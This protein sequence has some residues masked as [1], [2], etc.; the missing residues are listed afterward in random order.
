M[1]ALFSCSTRKNKFFNRKYHSI[2]AH[3]NAYFNG[4]EGLKEGI[5]TLSKS[6][7]D[8]YTTILPVYRLGTIENAQAVFPQ[9]DLSIK[10]GSMFIG[11]KEYNKW[12]D[13]CYMIIGQAQY[14]K[15]DYELAISTFDYMVSTFPNP[16]KSEAMLWIVRCLNEKHQYDKAQ[17]YIDQ[18]NESIKKKTANK[19][20]SEAK[21]ILNC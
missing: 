19:N 13:K 4:N 12:I 11:N 15:K 9:M 3:Y 8:D 5:T 17:Y 18:I 6:H 14:F 16:V 20:T 21:P 1:L 2:T 7:V 10:K